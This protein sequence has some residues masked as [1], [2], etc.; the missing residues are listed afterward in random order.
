G[1]TVY[2]HCGDGL[3]GIA[4]PTLTPRWQRQ[5]LPS[6][7]LG[8]IVTTG[9]GLVVAASDGGAA[10]VLALG[11]DGTTRWRTP[12]PSRYV[13]LRSDGDALFAFEGDPTVWRLDPRTGEVLWTHPSE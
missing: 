1:D 8:R 3:R 9:A 4:A 11:P 7:R 6:Q 5:F 2:V 13:E 12:L 10:E